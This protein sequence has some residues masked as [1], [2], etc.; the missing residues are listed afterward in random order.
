[1]PKRILMGMSTI[2][3]LMLGLVGFVVFGFVR[4]AAGKDKSALFG[5]LFVAVGAAVGQVFD[6]H[7]RNNLKTL[8]R[9]LGAITGFGGACAFLFPRHL[10]KGKVNPLAVVMV[11]GLSFALGWFVGKLFDPK[12]K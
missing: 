7:R 2:I 10:E 4:L 3:G 12:D 6:Y 8:W 1:M 5:L 11:L 9:V